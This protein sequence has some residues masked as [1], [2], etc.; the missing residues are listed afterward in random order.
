LNG[1]VHSINISGE[2]GVPK[3]SVPGAMIL[4]K[5]VEGDYNRFRMENLEGASKRAVSLFSLEIIEDLSEEGH[6]ISVGSTGENLTIKGIDWSVLD[7]GTT[8]QVGEAILELSEPCEPCSKIG[9]SFLGR[10][11]SRIDHELQFGWSRWLGSVV[12]E[13]KVSV[14]DD[15]RIVITESE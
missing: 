9:K 2:G 11:F 4:S 6:P 3:Q 14:G 12:R 8:L 15:V 13:G 1:L 7:R 10:K 5:G